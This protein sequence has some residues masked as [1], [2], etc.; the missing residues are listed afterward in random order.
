MVLKMS[1][2]YA[3]ARK[4]LGDVSDD[5]AEYQYSMRDTPAQDILS[6]VVGDLPM[7]GIY[8]FQQYIRFL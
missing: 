1:T 6:G 2:E 7:V 5:W 4:S 8:A 3:K